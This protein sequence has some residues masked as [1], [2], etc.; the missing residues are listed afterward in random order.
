M[1]QLTMHTKQNFE[2]KNVAMLISSKVQLNIFKLI[3]DA[4]VPSVL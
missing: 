1:L 4:T 2:T 3:H